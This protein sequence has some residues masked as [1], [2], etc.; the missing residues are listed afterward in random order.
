MECLYFCAVFIYYSIGFL[1]LSFF[2]FFNLGRISKLST[3]PQGHAERA[4]TKKA[5]QF[6]VSMAFLPDV[7]CAWIIQRPLETKP[8]FSIR[9]T[10]A[11]GLLRKGTQVM[12][13]PTFFLKSCIIWRCC[14]LKLVLIK[15]SLF[16]RL[17]SGIYIIKCYV[18]QAYK[19]EWHIKVG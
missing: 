11:P 16:S 5:P 14:F 13:H 12:T 2:L 17:W 9:I 7:L 6:N 15:S 19:Q 18:G 8:S 1:N 10:Q 3:Y 4:I